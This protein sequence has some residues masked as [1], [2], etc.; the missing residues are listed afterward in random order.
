MSLGHFEQVEK[1]FTFRLEIVVR[2]Q[3]IDVNMGVPYWDSSLDGLLPTPKDSIM[4]SE[5]FFGEVFKKNNS[6]QEKLKTKIRSTI[7]AM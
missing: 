1:V 5:L 6:P 7:T 3:L 4:F 2:R